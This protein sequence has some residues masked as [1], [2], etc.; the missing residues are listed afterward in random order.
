MY[1]CTRDWVCKSC[2]QQGHK[3]VDCPHDLDFP[4][5]SI[6]D[7]IEEENLIEHGDTSQAAD[8][9]PYNRSVQSP[10][11]NTILS[12][13]ITKDNENKDI[14]SKCHKKVKMIETDQSE[15]KQVKPGKKYYGQLHEIIKQA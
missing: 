7:G 12:K 6:Q 2:N 3:M 14:E 11:C 8:S 15:N 13:S 5:R 9:Q 1:Q 4:D 10:Q